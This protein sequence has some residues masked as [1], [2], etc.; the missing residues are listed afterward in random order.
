MGFVVD[1]VAMGQVL[2]EYVG[3][4]CQSFHRLFHIHHHPSSGAGAIGQ[5]LTDVPSGLSHTTT[6]NYFKETPPFEQLMGDPSAAFIVHLSMIMTHAS[7]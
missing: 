5:I 7:Q 2:A 3:S 4:S 1:K 6:R